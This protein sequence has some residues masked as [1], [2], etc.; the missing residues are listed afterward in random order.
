MKK[1]RSQADGKSATQAADAYIAA[2]LSA[3]Q[4]SYRHTFHAM[5]PIGWMN[6]PNGFNYAF[7]KY[8]LFYQFYPYGASWDSMHW[9]HYTTQDFIH[10][11]LE[12]TALAPDGANDSDGCFSGSSIVKDNKL[13]LMYTSVL[14]DI[15]TQSLAVSA[16]GVHFEK[17]GEVIPS[18]RLP[19]DALRTEFR[20]PKV[21]LRDGIY[22]ALLGS[23][24]ANG[25][26]QI[27]LYRSRDLLEW[28][29]VNVVRR[30]RL[31]TRGIYECPDLCELNGKDV[32]L[33]SPQ[34]YETKDWRYE[35]WQS[36]IYMVGKLDVEKGTFEQDYEDEIDGGFDF[37]AP[38][39]LKAPDGRVIMI[40]WMQ[41]W[42]RRMPTAQHG[43]AGSMILPRE[44][45]L[46]EG[47]LY[48]RP[49]RELKDYRWNEVKYAHKIIKEK[50]VLA[51]V[52]GKKTELH[53][54]FDLRQAARV[55]VEVFGNGT[56][57]AKIY[58]DRASDLVVFDRSGMGIDI[59]HDASEKDA[60]VRSVRVDTAGNRLEMLILL[61]V[62]SCE[63]FLND[64][65]RV[66]T[67]NVY[68]G[69]T[70]I[71]FFAENGEAEIVRLEKYDIIN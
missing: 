26:G 24:T 15:Q 28:E 53:V 25:E 2:N 29:Y 66:M 5:P 59:S 16:D 50:T 38:Q 22:Y 10:W 43:W 41:M 70:D 17:L 68:S 62:V 67:G 18:S 64:G 44:L 21:F 27:L 47:K 4:P 42:S 65:E 58:Y 6:D 45:S 34:G 51:G 48:Q 11:R 49:V 12:P 60:S 7:G 30:D 46:Q 14:A 23:R 69:G 1:N 3:V 37:Y 36:A 32:M 63:V 35:N 31:T 39:T 33:A 13:Y 52:C 9:G 54:L 20:D 71:S 8:H 57:S 56:R 19:Q 61:D 40:G 55:G